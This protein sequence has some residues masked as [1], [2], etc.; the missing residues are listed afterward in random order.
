MLQPYTTNI[1][2]G[3]FFSIDT[4]SLNNPS[5]PF[6]HYLQEFDKYNYMNLWR[7]L[8]GTSQIL[9]AHVSI[10]MPGNSLYSVLFQ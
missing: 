6:L 10:Y 2:F 8:G 1:S 4:E 5:S 7:L 9:N 3:I